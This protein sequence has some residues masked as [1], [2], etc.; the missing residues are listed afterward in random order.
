[1]KIEIWFLL[2]YHIFTPIQFLLFMK[3][4]FI[5]NCLKEA[6]SIKSTVHFCPVI[7]LLFLNEFICKSVN[8]LT[9]KSSNPMAWYVGFP[10]SEVE[11][12]VSLFKGTISDR[13]FQTSLFSKPPFF[14]IFREN[15]TV[16][17]YLYNNSLGNSIFWKEGQF[18]VVGN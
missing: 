15:C 2:K 13:L 5:L 6:F 8:T 10:S 14:P 4:F 1:M 7:N 16:I 11:A 3:Y 9:Y 12:A 17:T 18:F